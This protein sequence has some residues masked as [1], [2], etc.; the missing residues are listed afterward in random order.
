MEGH[1]S[2]T[3]GNTFTR[4]IDLPAE[5]RCIVIE[6]VENKSD[7]L[8]LGWVS[9]PDRLEG[10]RTVAFRHACSELTI[11]FGAISLWHQF[12]YCGTQCP[13][14]VGTPLQRLCMLMPDP[15]QNSNH[16]QK[17]DRGIAEAVQ[18]LNFQSLGN[19]K[20]M[21]SKLTD[22]STEKKPDLKAPWIKQQFDNLMNLSSTGGHAISKTDTQPIFPE[23]RTLC[24]PYRELEALT[25]LGYSSA[26]R[27]VTA[28]ATT[29]R[30]KLAILETIVPCPVQVLVEGIYTKCE[31]EYVDLEVWL[32]ILEETMDGLMSERDLLQETL[33]L[34]DFAAKQMRSH[35]PSAKWISEG[36]GLRGDSTGATQTLHRV[37][38]GLWR[39]HSTQPSTKD[40]T[41]VASDLVNYFAIKM[42]AE[43]EQ[44][45][46]DES[47]VENEQEPFIPEFELHGADEESIATVKASMLE[48]LSSGSR[49]TTGEGVTKWL[50]VL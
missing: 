16:T 5:L 46:M 36:P 14:M 23:A 17:K 28:L 41:E 4:Y 7:I 12:E 19:T 40:L 2:E 45:L 48:V 35:W 43:V 11:N 31:G 37:D 42:D 6:Q 32:R 3:S 13:K 20:R 9:H 47:Q 1:N 33:Y 26:S 24:L 25:Y 49:F 18:T 38:L 15:S 22:S 21:L 27:D 34:S 50:R 44:T 30:D 8:N 29:I 10:D 39:K